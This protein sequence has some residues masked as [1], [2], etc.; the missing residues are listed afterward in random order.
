VSEERKAV[1]ENEAMIEAGKS[2]TIPELAEKDLKI[3]EL[4]EVV[5]QIPAT[6]NAAE[7][8]GIV[9]TAQMYGS[10]SKAM[11][12]QQLSHVKEAKAYKA[13]GMTW[14]EYCKSI[15]MEQTTVDR[16]LKDLRPL[17]EAFAGDFQRVSGIP[18]KRLRK[19]GTQMQ[20]GQA[21]FEGD[22]LTIGKRQIALSDENF[23][24]IEEAID[25]VNEKLKEE[26][27]KTRAKTELLKA[28]EEKL[29]KDEN[30]KAAKVAEIESMEFGSDEELQLHEHVEELQH[31]EQRMSLTTQKA[32]VYYEPGMDSKLLASFVG[33]LD[34]LV[35]VAS[36]MLQE[37]TAETGI[38][39]ANLPDFEWLPY[40]ASEELLNLILADSP[41]APSD[42]Q[43][44]FLQMEMEHSSIDLSQRRVLWEAMMLLRQHG[45]GEMMELDMQQGW[46]LALQ[47]RPHKGRKQV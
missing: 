17:M 45:L 42:F 41:P 44:Y 1:D 6:T 27:A 15:G 25:E 14:A 40:E 7:V 12:Y 4:T 21:A 13:L 23:E 29:V 22:V 32:L 33:T 10:F 8:L 28:A 18:L 26:R 34:Q 16:N 5:E 47:Q 19:L 38:A 46:A 36:R 30:E 11:I 35:M 37:V 3:Q 20:G 9:K 31:L 39:V 2:M 43:N 24:E